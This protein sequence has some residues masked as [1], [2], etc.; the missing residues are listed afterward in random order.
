MNRSERCHALA[1]E[2]HSWIKNK[3]FKT[4]PE[5]SIE[6]IEREIRDHM[7]LDGPAKNEPTA[8]LPEQSKK[9]MR[10][11]TNGPCKQCGAK[12]DSDKCLFPNDCHALQAMCGAPEALKDG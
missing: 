2:L 12:W 11:F 10:D 3:D 7:E 5:P 4:W 1:V 6:E 9:S 8:K